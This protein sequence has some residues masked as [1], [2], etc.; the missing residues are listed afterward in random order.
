[1]PLVLTPAHTVMY[2]FLYLRETTGLEWATETLGMSLKSPSLSFSTC[3][4]RALS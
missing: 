1:M 2:P 3:P 4:I